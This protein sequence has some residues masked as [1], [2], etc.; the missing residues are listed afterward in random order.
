MAEDYKAFSPVTVLTS[1]PGQMRGIGTAYDAAK[2]IVEEWPPER[3]GSK[4]SNAKVILLQC[5]SGQCSPA[6]ARVSFIE[7]ARESHI[8]I[9]PP[10]NEPVRSKPNWQKAARA[11]RRTE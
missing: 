2:F 10:E 3:G 9:A 1:Q 6:I 5:L 8:Y 11:W 7:A 4:L